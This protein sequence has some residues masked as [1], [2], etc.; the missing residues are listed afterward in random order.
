MKKR[1][2]LFTTK[3]KKYI[4][5]EAKKDKQ[6][7]SVA[8][9]IK[10]T[11]SKSI[12]FDAVTEHQMKALLAVREGLF[13]YKIPDAGWQNPFDMFLM[14]QQ[15]AYIVLAFLEPRKKASVWFV[16]ALVYRDIIEDNKG[17]RKSSTET[18]LQK[19]SDEYDYWCRNVKV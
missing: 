5:A 17:V 14:S 7:L 11:T 16:D 2:A 19:Y 4:R 13:M 9:E 3:L 18:L 8:Y 12:P 6:P 10:V 15:E 1:E